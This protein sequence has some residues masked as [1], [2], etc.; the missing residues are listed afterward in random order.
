MCIVGLRCVVASK[1]NQVHDNQQT[2]VY[3]KRAVVVDIV[4][5]NAVI[6]PW[7][8]VVKSEHAFIAALAVS[9]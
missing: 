9:H 4:S 8:V 5:S 7:T 2:A 6:E 3:Q 1:C